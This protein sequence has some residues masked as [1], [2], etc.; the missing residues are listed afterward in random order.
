MMCRPLVT[1]ISVGA[2]VAIGFV[3]GMQLML[4]A[5]REAERAAIVRTCR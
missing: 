1:L 2:L 5:D 3:T 4:G